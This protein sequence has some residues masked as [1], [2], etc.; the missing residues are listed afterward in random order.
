MLVARLRRG[1]NEAAARRV[2]SVLRL[3]RTSR[4]PGRSFCQ[5]VSVSEKGPV[6]FSVAAVT[7]VGL[8]LAAPI[9]NAQETF[10]IE[11]IVRDTDGRALPGAEITVDGEQ[12][13]S[14]VADE[15]GRFEVS[16]LA[17]GTYSLRARLVGYREQRQLVRVGQSPTTR[18]TFVLSP[19][20]P[21]PR[22]SVGDARDER[23]P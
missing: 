21:S 23:R 22:L 10:R 2:S 16:S 5:T 4:R 3:F 9:V 14:V 17:A 11:G 7:L 12:P 20:A 13:A 19:A 1:S 15:Q 18:V 6:P 8:L